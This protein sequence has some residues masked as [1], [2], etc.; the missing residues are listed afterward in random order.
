V[1][2]RSSTG[3]GARGAFFFSLGSAA[4]L[5]RDLAARAT[6]EKIHA[7]LCD[8]HKREVKM[9]HKLQ[10]APSFS[11]LCPIS[12]EVMIDPVCTDDGYTYERRNIEHWLASHNTS[13]VTNAVLP[14]KTLRPNHALKSIITEWHERQRA[15]TLPPATGH[16][17]RRYL[18]MQASSCGQRR[19]RETSGQ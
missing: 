5:A 3:Q 16:A 1:G 12:Q 4:S 19:R 14:N 7:L 18:P 15:M 6:F 17:P 9:L 10:S 11:F 8:M 13:P 2:G